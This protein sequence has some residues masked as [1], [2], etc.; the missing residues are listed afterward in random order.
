M[1]QTTTTHLS[2]NYSD[3]CHLLMEIFNTE[4]VYIKYFRF[5]NCCVGHPQFLEIVKTCWDKEVEGNIMWRFYQK[6]KKLSNTLSS[7]SMREFGGIFQKVRE[8][9]EKYRCAEENIMQ[10]NNEINREILNDINVNC[11]R[12]LKMEDYIIK[13]NARLLRFQEGDTNCNF[14]CSLIRGRMRKL[15]IH[16]IS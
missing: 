3:H 1:P 12:Y 11:I 16:G 4:E 15:F 6:L 7:W 9:E 10:N 2:S 8:Y 5:V 13:Q 14:F